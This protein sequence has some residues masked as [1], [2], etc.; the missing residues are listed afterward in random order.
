LEYRNVVTRDSPQ[1]DIDL[2][3]EY[4]LVLQKAGQIGEAIT[5]YNRAL[6]L[7]V[8][9][10]SGVRMETFPADFRSDGSD[11]DPAEM[12]AVTHLMRALNSS[13]DDA[14]RISSER[15]MALAAAPDSPIV[16]IYDS[17]LAH[18]AKDAAAIQLLKQ[19]SAAQNAVAIAK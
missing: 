6:D 19:Q 14:G 12:T 17:I 3:T 8:K 7:S 10:Y 2:L 4:V 5:Y 16:R 15:L 9:G 13:D 1:F 18:R 11:Y